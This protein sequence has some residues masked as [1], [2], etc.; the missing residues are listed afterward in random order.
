M[1]SVTKSMLQHAL[2][3]ASQGLPV[4]PL[5]NAEPD[6]TCTCGMPYCRNQGKHPRT[7]NGL[8]D[9]T[10]QQAL[11]RKWWSMWPN[12]SIAGVGGKFLCLDVDSKNNGDAS[13]EKLIADNAPL[14]NTAIAET[15]KYN[16]TRGKHYW[17]SVPE[18]KQV[19]SKVNVR[20]GI[21]IRC[22]RAYA[23]LPPST[24]ASGVQYEWLVPFEEHTEAPGWLLSLVPAAIPGQ[25]KW[26]PPENFR[27]AKDKKDFLTGI[28]QPEPGEQRSFLCAAARSLLS[29]GKTIDETAELLWE[30][31]D[32]QGGLCCCTWSDDPWTLEQVLFIVEDEFRKPPSTPLEK[33]F[34]DEESDQIFK[35][36]TDMGNGR[37]LVSCYPEDH[38][39]FIPEWG[40]WYIWNQEEAKFVEDK[41]DIL[42]KRW[43]EETEVLKQEAKVKKNASVWKAHAKASRSRGRTEACLYFARSRAAISPKELNKDPF[44]LNCRNGVL[45]LKTG[46]LLDPNPSYRLTKQCRGNYRP[47]TSSDL[48]EEIVARILPNEKVRDFVQKIFGY[49]LTGSIEE[50]KFFYFYGPP[51]GG[52]TTL[53]EAFAWLLGNYAEACEPAT[54]LAKRVEGGPTEDIARLSNARMV[55]T[56]EIDEG[57]RWSEG[58]INHLTGGDK[59]TARFLHQNP[60]EFYPQFKLFFSA[61]HM[62]QVSGS[63]NSG[64]WRRMIIIPFDHVIPEEQR[65]PM[66]LN[67]LRAQEH[68]DAILTWA[69][70][71]CKRW[72]T[73]YS[74][75]NL[76]D[77]PQRVKDEVETYQADSNHVLEFANEVLIR[78]GAGEDRIPKPDLYGIYRGWCDAV[79]RKAFYTSNKLT[80]ELGTLGY[81]YK[82]AQFQGKVRDCWVGIKTTL[83]TKKNQ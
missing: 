18:G 63:V 53:L 69:V 55:R 6:G 60:F 29:T 36:C 17:F 9:A 5:H 43:E 80:R 71:G 49:A 7:R 46:E 21:D 3:Y 35:E 67:K 65:D 2:E 66:L 22:A 25:S 54:F 59:V 31:H 74:S 83:P 68:L 77:V 72:M 28:Y 78:T 8:T 42:V 32:G 45:N 37:R 79:G 13:L 58:R 48:W 39:F 56:H 62:P 15:G 81:Q 44:F 19:A 33:D 50:H 27:M 70:E 61:N 12:A 14:P 10:T 64:F 41:G 76:M 16:G 34:S 73:D 23:V 57:P 82:P 51:A 1:S 38:L 52:K 20:K 26:E 24:H 11:I 4:I 75:G 30:G 40:K 47:G